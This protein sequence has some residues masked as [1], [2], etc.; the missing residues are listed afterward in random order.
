MHVTVTHVVDGDGWHRLEAREYPKQKPITS[1]PCGYMAIAQ[2]V[3]GKRLF[4]AV[5]DY[6]SGG[7]LVADTVYEVTLPKEA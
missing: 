2:L 4:I 3:V 5:T 6:H 7:P 1:Q